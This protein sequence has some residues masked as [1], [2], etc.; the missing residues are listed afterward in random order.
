MKK[1][2][3]MDYFTYFLKIKIG[4][5]DGFL[6]AN[7]FVK[8]LMLVTNFLNMPRMTSLCNW[9]PWIMYNYVSRAGQ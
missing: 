3:I 1:M 6:G 4:I 5:F 2:Y 7:K 8:S 9:Y